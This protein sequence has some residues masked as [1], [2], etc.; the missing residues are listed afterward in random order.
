MEESEDDDQHEEAD[1][2]YADLWASIEGYYDENIDH[3]D[4]TNNL[5]KET[6]KTID[7]ISI[8][9]IDERA[10]LLKALNR[11]FETHD[12][13]SA[14]KKEM[15]RMVESYNT[16]FSNISV[17]DIT[18][19]KQLESPPVVH[20]AD[21]GKGVV[22]EETK[23]HTM[24]LVPAST[25]VRQDPDELIR[26]PYE[27]YGKLYNLTNSE[28]IKVVHE[29]AE[30]DGIDPKIIESVKVSEGLE[31][32]S[33]MSNLGLSLVIGLTNDI[34]TTLVGLSSSCSID[35][36]TLGDRVVRIE[37]LHKGVEEDIPLNACSISVTI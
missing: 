27:I 8:A 32:D 2:S 19:P 13:D 12:V 26:I 29:E 17:I 10:K 35:A 1:A 9:G 16:T 11:V 24:K 23:E 30:K 18:P 14:L 15:K 31:D 6:M 21:K 7:Y 33:I 4:Q 34:R 5:V 3:I 37:A 28:L 22:T 36:W 20:K 25:D